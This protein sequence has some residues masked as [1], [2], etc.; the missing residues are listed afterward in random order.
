VK[1]S[2]RI[3]VV[4]AVALGG[5]VAFACGSSDETAWSPG[6]FDAAGTDGGTSGTSGSGGRAGSGSDGVGGSGGTAIALPDSGDAAGQQDACGYATVAATLKPALLLFLIDRT[7]SMNCNPPPTQTTAQCDATPD[8][9]EPTLPSKWEIT[10]DALVSALQQLKGTVPPPAVGMQLFNSDDYCGHSTQPEVKIASLNDSQVNAITGLLDAVTPKGDTPIVAA[11]MSAYEYLGKQTFEG[12][13][14][15]V[16]LTD[17][18]ETCDPYSKDLLIAKAL[19]ATWA[20]IRT[21][22]LGAPGSE[23]GRAFLSRVAFNGGTPSSPTCD[24]TN[25]QTNAG[26]CHMDMTQPGMVFK[27]ELSKALKTVSGAALTCEIDM[28]SDDAGQADPD[29]VN[30]FFT[31]GDGGST[32]IPMDAQHPCDETNQ[33]WQYTDATSKRIRVCGPTCDAIKTQ[34]Q[35]T[36]SVQLGCK[37]IGPK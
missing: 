34:A 31:S 13:K 26:D 2:H 25:T 32:L 37:T 7:G 33:G 8:K 17:G 12:N 29:K 35:G 11:T 22:V 1:N 30:V 14:F 5:A 21:F 6:G 23:N 3:A 9:I 20:G 27:D 18:N 28:P 19:E 15:V 16:L 36:L 4:S 24:H 10:T